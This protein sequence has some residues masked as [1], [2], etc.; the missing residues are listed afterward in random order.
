[1]ESLKLSLG[2]DGYAQPS[3]VPVK[4]MPEIRR[5]RREVPA[6]VQ[7]DHKTDDEYLTRLGFPPKK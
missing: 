4:I 1:M 6:L 5:F 7:P 3:S 2:W